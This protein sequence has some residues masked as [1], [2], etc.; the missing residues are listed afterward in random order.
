MAIVR[1][2]SVIVKLQIR[3]G[4]FPALVNTNAEYG[5]GGDTYA[6]GGRGNDQVGGI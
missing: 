2:I 1:A 4:S 3:E 5:Y 6:C